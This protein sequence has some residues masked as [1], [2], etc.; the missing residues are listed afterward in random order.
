MSIERFVTIL[1]P[2]FAALSG[3]IVAWTAK[4]F[5]GGPQLDPA[6]ISGLFALGATAGIAAVLKWLH[7]RA[8]YVELKARFDHELALY[9]ST[10]TKHPEIAGTVADVEKVFISHQDEI[11]AKLAALVKAPP[12]VQDVADEILAAASAR[13]SSTTSTVETY[14]D[15]IPQQVSPTGT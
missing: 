15:P 6:E 3:A 9:G 12:S 4:N 13:R 11:V 5:P 7:G 10:E 8:H 1:S 14:L 2:L